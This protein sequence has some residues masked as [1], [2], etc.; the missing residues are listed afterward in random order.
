MMKCKL[1]ELLYHKSDCFLM[2]VD[3][4]TFNFFKCADKNPNT[5]IL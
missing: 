1:Y 2:I 4:L 5:S 3:L